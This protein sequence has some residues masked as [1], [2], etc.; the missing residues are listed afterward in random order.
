M[1][2]ALTP[3]SK[4][5]HCQAHQKGRPDNLLFIRNPSYR[6]KQ[7]LPWVEWVEDLLS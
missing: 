6:Q 1:L 3:P 5:T 2:M 4:D 7:T